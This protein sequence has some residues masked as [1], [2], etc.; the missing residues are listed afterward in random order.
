MQ[1]YTLGV[2]GINSSNALLFHQHFSICKTV[3]Q[4]TLDLFA[5]FT[6]SN[7]PQDQVKMPFL[8]MTVVYF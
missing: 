8:F 4:I 2:A 5:S 7:L 1:H 6:T 3:L